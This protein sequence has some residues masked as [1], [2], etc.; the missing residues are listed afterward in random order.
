MKE[1]GID[2]GREYLQVS[3]EGV[4]I[5]KPVSVCTLIELEMARR[6]VNK[7]LNDR[8][9]KELSNDAG[10]IAEDIDALSQVKSIINEEIAR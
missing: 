7:L 9:S 1:S 4:S 3:Y 10:Q 8:Y 5:D 6:A 2:M